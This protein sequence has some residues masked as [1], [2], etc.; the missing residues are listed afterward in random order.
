MV[1]LKNELYRKVKEKCLL[2]DQDV[3]FYIKELWMMELCLI[4]N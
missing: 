1:E 3:E 4:L 2:M